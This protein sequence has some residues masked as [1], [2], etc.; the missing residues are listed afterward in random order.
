MRWPSPPDKVADGRSS[1]RYPSPTVSRKRSRFLISCKNQTGNLFG[2]FV[3]LNLIEGLDRVFD[4]HVR[5]IPRYR[6]HRRAPRANPNADAGRRTSEQVI[7]ETISS[8]A[9][10]IFSLGASFSRSR[11]HGSAPFQGPLYV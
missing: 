10:R 5:C 11:N 3:E 2:S 4:R 1:V 6:V 7:G 9:V 8:R